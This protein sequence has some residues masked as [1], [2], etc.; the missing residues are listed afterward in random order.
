M[1]PVQAR[2]L[3][4]V[5]KRRIYLDH[6]ESGP[7]SYRVEAALAGLGDRGPTPELAG[8]SIEVACR[9]LARLFN[10]PAETLSLTR[11][12]SDA[13]AV[14][15]SG[16]G[17][18][19]GDN[20]V[21]R[22]APRGDEAQCWTAL[23]ER[24]VE[25]RRVPL[26]GGRIT[27][28]DVIAHL[29]GSTRI[30]V[31]P[32]VDAWNGA[33]VDLREIGRECDRRGIVFTVDASQS[34]G[35]IQLDLSSLPVDF[36]VADTGRWLMGPA[37][38]TIRYCRPEL[39]RRLRPIPTPAPH[40]GAAAEAVALGVAVDLLL[41][42]GPQVIESR[43]LQLALMLSTGLRERGYE[44]VAPGP[45]V[46]AESSGIVAFRRPGSGATEVMRDLQ[47]AGVVASEP[48][49]FVRLSPHFYNTESEMARVLDVLAPE[50]ALA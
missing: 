6:A 23:A 14:L 47:A 13:M 40:G 45:N 21:M 7:T 19:P 30:V 29:D 18:H 25:L 37:G 41:E 9:S 11:S 26:R 27:P 22:E 12:S 35:M 46:P 24:G 39:L 49:D 38:A 2:N 15:A 42:V 4:P 33:R 28:E 31:L 32:H 16:V 36:L 3:F 10:A 44:V 20:V 5:T 50:S 48:A 34:A 43:A 8:Q 1:N 17:W